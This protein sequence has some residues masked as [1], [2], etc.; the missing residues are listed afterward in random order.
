MKEEPQVISTA[1]MNYPKYLPPPRSQPS[2]P[3]HEVKVE[4]ISLHKARVSKMESK[5]EPKPMQAIR[6]RSSESKRNTDAV[7][8]LK[9]MQ[10]SKTPNRGNSEERPERF[11]LALQ[12]GEKDELMTEEEWSRLNQ[13]EIDSLNQDRLMMVLGVDRNAATPQEIEQILDP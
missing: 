13:L 2:L 6:G 4:R 7:L 1:A 10:R 5:M 3:T 12:D 8:G 11:E 9:P